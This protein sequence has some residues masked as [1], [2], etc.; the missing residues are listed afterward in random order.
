MRFLVITKPSHPLP[1]EAAI[2]ML[3]GM[4]RWVE[5]NV[6]SGKFEQIWAFAGTQGGGGV[7]NVE[8]HEELDDV[9]SEF[10]FAPFSQVEILALTDLQR[11]LDKGKQVAAAM[12]AAMAAH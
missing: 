12:M 6:A 9:M 5:K 10:P 2:G 11:S 4:S 1:M 3:E 7:L 8:S